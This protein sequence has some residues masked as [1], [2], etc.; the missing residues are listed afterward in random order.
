MNMSD[1]YHL[2]IQQAVLQKQFD[3][4]GYHH[5][6]VFRDLQIST[7]EIVKDQTK[8]Q[9]YRIE[10]NEAQFS[11]GL[12]T[13]SVEYEKLFKIDDTYLQ[14]TSDYD[15]A[16]FGLQRGGGLFQ[17]AISLSPNRITY[18]RRTYKIS[19]ILSDSGGFFGAVNGLFVLLSQIFTYNSAFYFLTPELFKVN[20]KEDKL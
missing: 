7:G 14:E 9:L 6:R 3:P 12:Y 5:E 10:Q 16:L 4:Y 19:N 2:G 15:P 17:S 18:Q 13:E 8:S 1:F 20:R 11:D